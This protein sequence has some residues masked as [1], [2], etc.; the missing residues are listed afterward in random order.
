MCLC[1]C[2]HVCVCVHVH[3]YVFR[4]CIKKLNDRA[5]AEAKANAVIDEDYKKLGPMT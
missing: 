4:L 2:E 5:A 3:V 1:V